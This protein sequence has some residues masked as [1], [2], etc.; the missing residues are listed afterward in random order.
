MITIIPAI[1]VINGQCVRLT[2]G[3]FDSKKIYDNNPLT[4]A[5]RF[6]GMGIKRLHL[7]DLDGARQKRIVNQHSLREVAQN[8]SLQ[9]DF[10][11]GVQSDADIELAFQC[12]AAQVTAG[13]IA[14]KDKAL[15]KA[16]LKRYG[17]DKIILGADVRDGKIAVSGW[18]DTTEIQLIDF[19]KEY[20]ALGF[21]ETICTDISCDGMLAGPA[22]ALYQ[23]I[24]KEIPAMQ[25]IASGGVGSIADVQRLNESG[26]DSVIIGK[27]IYEG[28]I[29]LEELKPYLC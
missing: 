21:R 26:I 25:L 15:V 4:V 10:G 27:A 8:T 18:Q 2:R 29:K 16:W 17:S 20:Y 22:F 6:E 11:G 28:R 24:K 5:R 9:I 12:G 14:V 19:L 1:D 13:S 23:S 3:E 7:V